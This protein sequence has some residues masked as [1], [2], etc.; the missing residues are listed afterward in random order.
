MNHSGFY[1][2]SMEG[3]INDKGVNLMGQKNITDHSN[4]IKPI[5]MEGSIFNKGF[6]HKGLFLREVTPTHLSD[7]LPVLV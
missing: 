2:I 5:C 1:P 3:S 6:N 7:W 4:M